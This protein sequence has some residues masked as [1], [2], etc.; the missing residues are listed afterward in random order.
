VVII[1][2]RFIKESVCTSDN[3]NN[4]SAEEE[5]F[6]Y[7]LI[8]NCDDYGLMDA[9]PSI[10]RAKLFPLKVDKIKEKEI[11]GWLDALIKNELIFLYE[12]EGRFYLKMTSWANHQQTR[13]N[14]SK[15][16]NPDTDNI[17]LLACDI[18]CYQL[19]HELAN[20]DRTRI[21]IS[22]TNTNTYKEKG[23]M[24][25]KENNYF[26]PP[27]LEEVKAYCLERKNS[28]DPQKWHDFYTAKNWMIGKNKM[29]DWKAAVRTWER[30]NKP[31]AQKQQKPPNMN[32]FQQRKPEDLNNIYEEV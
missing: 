22:N 24:G 11:E 1:P 28:V 23:G 16:P 6:F 4:L 9:R 31:G 5:V 20:S 15:F 10:L 30:E 25:E 26:T 12:Y 29:K 7:R 3:L 32:N 27:T 8:V 17:N 2:N 18:K 21:R 19:F 14:K 13:A